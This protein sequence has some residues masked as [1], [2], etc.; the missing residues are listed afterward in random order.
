M[1]GSNLNITA[2]EVLL[3]DMK[4]HV[5]KTLG[6]LEDSLKI[7]ENWTRRFKDE[8]KPLK[9]SLIHYRALRNGTEKD[10]LRVYS[11]DEQWSGPQEVR[12]EIR[13]LT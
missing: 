5:Q 9:Q 12:E 11:S 13:N 1:D 3:N 4:W 2:A 8:I 10:F 6:G 7:N